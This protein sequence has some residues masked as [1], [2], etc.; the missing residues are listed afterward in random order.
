MFQELFYQ[1]GYFRVHQFLLQQFVAPGSLND[2]CPTLV[3]FVELAPHAWFEF[4]VEI[5]FYLMAH[6]RYLARGAYGYFQ[7]QPTHGGRNVEIAPL[8]IGGII[9][10]QTSGHCLVADKAVDLTVVCRCNNYREPRRISLLEDTG[11]PTQSMVRHQNRE[12]VGYGGR[13]YDG[14]CTSS[15]ECLCFTSCDLSTTND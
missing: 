2:E 13:K 7:W 6:V 15:D 5:F 12:L 10:Q 1:G 4:L 3:Y 11:H 8:G 9:N 14:Q